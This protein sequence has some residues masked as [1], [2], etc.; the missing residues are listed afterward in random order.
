MMRI[1]D[2]G[3]YTLIELVV[4]VMIIGILAA[5]AVPE[6]LR[7]VENGRA[8]DA[9]AISN[10]IGTTNRMF[11]LDHSGFFV[12]GQF[13]AACG[14]GVCPAVVNAT[15]NNP[16]VL[17]WCRYLSDQDWGNKP[18]TFDACDGSVA[19][20]CAGMGA[21]TQVSGAHRLAGAGAPYNG[22]GYTMNTAGVIT[23]FGGAPAPTY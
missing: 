7:T 19:G 14:A 3:G 21:G 8:D 20:A 4:T 6:Y 12:A 13:A 15:Q 2:H 16:C 18:Y 9:V 23:A 22:W 5:F 10:M 17:V 1:Q 11:A